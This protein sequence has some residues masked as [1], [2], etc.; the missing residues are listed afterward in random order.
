MSEQLTHVVI[1][2]TTVVSLGNGRQ[3]TKPELS[4][5]F[6]KCIILFSFIHPSHIKTPYTGLLGTFSYL[7]F[8][9]RWECISKLTTHLLDHDCFDRSESLQQPL[10]W[11]TSLY[12]GIRGISVTMLW[13]PNVLTDF[14]KKVGVTNAAYFNVDRRKIEF[15]CAVTT[16][17]TVFHAL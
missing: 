5:F 8:T 1:A 15:Y 7:M 16:P 6:T 4:T 11:P 10:I 2:F 13:Q 3:T 17:A 14:C 9:E 12:R